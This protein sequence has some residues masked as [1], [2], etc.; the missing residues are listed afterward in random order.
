MA[1]GFFSKIFGGSGGGARDNLGKV[2][3]YLDARQRGLAGR[4]VT[5]VRTGDG[6]PVLSA[7]ATTI[8]RVQS[9]DWQARQK[10]LE[11]ENNYTHSFGGDPA[12]LARYAEVLSA[13]RGVKPHRASY[14]KAISDETPDTVVNLFQ[15]MNQRRHRGLKADVTDHPQPTQFD[16]VV[17]AVQILGGT[18]VDIISTTVG[19]GYGGMNVSVGGAQFS[20]HIRDFPASH[21]VQSLKR[22]KTTDQANMLKHLAQYPVAKDP[23]FLDYLM[24]AAC[25][26]SSQLRTASAKLL[27]QQSA[28][29]VE[30]RALPLLDAGAA[31]ARSSAVQILGGIGSETA[32]AAMKKRLETEKTQDVIAAIEHY[33]GAGA[34][35][36]D[37]P[38]GSYL[39]ADGSY[40]DI[41]ECVPLI[42]DQSSPFGESD[43]KELKDLDQ[44]RYD[45]AVQRHADQL[46]NIKEGKKGWQNVAKPQKPQKHSWS[47]DIFAFLNK[48]IDIAAERRKRAEKTKSG[49]SVVI[50]HHFDQTSWAMKA[51]PQ[52]PHLRLVQ[53]ALLTLHD[54]KGM[55]SPYASPYCQH[56]YGLLEGGDID[57]RQVMA[58]AKDLGITLNSANHWNPAATN[59]YA[60]TAKDY[61][62]LQLN[63]ASSYGALPTLRSSWPITAERLNDVLGALPPR[64]TDVWINDRALRMLADLP[65]LPMAAIDTVLFAALDGRRRISDPAQKL[66]LDV[67]GIDDRLIVT[68]ADKRQAVRAKAA[69]FLAD[70]QATAAVPALVKRLKTEKSE[71]ARASMISAIATLGGDTAPYLGRAAILKEAESFVAKLPNAKID[72]LQMDTAPSLKW[73]DGKPV[74]P[75]VMDGWLRLAL[76]LKSPAGSPLF[77]LY[78]DQLDP[79]TVTAFCDWVLESWI[80]FDTWKPA[81]DALREKAQKQA[82]ADKAAGRSW[83]SSWTVDQIANYLLQNWTSGYPNSGSDAKGILALTHR[84]TPNRSTAAIAAYLK[85]HGK[86][87]SQAKCLVEVLVGMGTPE[88]LQVVVATATRFK[89]RTVREL[90]EQSVTEIAELRGWSED[91]LAD[92]SVPSGGFEED[93]IMALEVGEEAKPY[94]AR[95]GSDLAV[96]LFNPDGKEVKT[97]PAGKDA[98]TKESKALLSAAKKTVKTVT[99]QQT[100]RLYDAMIGARQWAVSAWDADIASHPI[101]SRLS[102]RVIW[103][104]LDDDGTALVLFRPTPEGDRLTA[105]GDDADLSAV[106]RVDIAHTAT[107]SEDIRS[108]WVTHL[109]DFEVAPL[110][111]Q[112]SRPMQV[113]DQAQQKATAIKDR[114]GW[115]T[116]AFKLRTAATKA[117]YDRGPVEDGAGFHVYAKTFRN[118]GI[119]AELEFT[120]SYV[121][122]DNIPVAITQ[123]VF[124]KS[125]GR[126][127]RTLPLGEVPAMVLSEAWNDLHDIASIGAFDAD[128]KK[129]GLY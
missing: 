125:D 27:A 126:I 24:E 115:L 25:A 54:V 116:E 34:V 21:F 86:R 80:A 50:S 117:N 9:Q 109:S 14:N 39:A 32:L 58:V 3:H 22:R 107:V 93:G 28:V 36:D 43:L 73:A 129:K 113:L 57:L 124:Y 59:V 108:A 67:D 92:R 30:E 91:E 96:K 51:A 104:G 81:T 85:N 69:A 16:D 106:K 90:A 33:V 103:R 26:N 119:R 63:V 128:W 10:R 44:K 118:A 61:M 94:A 84:A 42:D 76:K 127:Q 121:P 87:V 23:A 12:G 99:A 8:P 68:L 114:E 7:L 120:G 72:W 101:L 70:R 55:L 88:A 31:V 48:P 13:A 89:Q 66:L 1:G 56:V 100:T 11:L 95:L 102:E 111:A 82:Q 105:D 112:I 38:D 2:L 20:D 19:A 17:E 4:A 6:R 74:D 5:Y 45:N 110:F 40:V 47:E 83:Y 97:I 65:K 122:E 37:A 29:A 46:R 35:V 60:A 77:G 78:F 18:R 62:G 64:I 71:S 79:A 75:V 49:H 41:P 98:N 52:L 53:F 123:M 15:F